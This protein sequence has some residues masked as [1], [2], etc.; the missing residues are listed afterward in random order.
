MKKDSIVQF[1]CFQTD[2]ALDTF[3]GAWEQYSKSLGKGIEVSLQQQ[4]LS[5]NKFKYVSRHVGPKDDFRFVFVKGRK[6]E[7][8]ND[9]SV[10]VIQAGGYLPMQLECNN[11]A[12]SNEIKILVFLTNNDTE[13]SVYKDLKTYR[14]LNIY[15]PYYE[16][17]AYE[18]IL[19]YYVKTAE[20]EELLQQIKLQG[21]GA[22]TGSYKECKLQQYVNS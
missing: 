1:V 15:Q 7:H 14:Y 4:A 3:V 20:A 8:F 2:V 22:E 12:A 11:E 16:S 21:H 17:C 19:E 18:Y 13:L 6:P 9:C 10:R 5:K